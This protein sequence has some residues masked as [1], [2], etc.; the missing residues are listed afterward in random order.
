MS[1]R[2][3]DVP[4]G[5]DAVAAA[6]LAYQNPDGGFGNALEPDCRTPHSQPEATRIGLSVLA[7]VGRL[8]PHVAQQAAGWLGSIVTPEG[9]IPF[10][11]PTVAGYPR[12]PWWEPEGDPPPPNINPTAALVALLR[13]ADAQAPW[14]DEAEAWCFGAFDRM[15]RTGEAPNQY[16]VPGLADLCVHAADSERSRRVL[17][18]LQRFV[19][20]GKV[21]PLDAAVR[22]GN[23]THTP[24]DVA[25]HPDHPLRSAFSDDVIEKFLDR[26]ESDQQAD[27]G[28]PI[29]WPAPGETAVWEWRGA[30][31]VDALETL[32]AYGRLR[33]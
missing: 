27:G 11:L 4:S 6:V 7:S 18:D 31:T 9:G 17:A 33:V 22:P 21:I 1:H 13:A 20:D 15:V 16:Q 23:D 29:D 32:R 19:R 5:P 26:L 8:G 2:F 25:A 24:L 30:R 12:A 10:C 3:G 14:L 28:W